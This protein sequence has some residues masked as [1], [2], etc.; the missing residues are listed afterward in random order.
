MLA[1]LADMLS[2]PTDTKVVRP[3]I[4]AVTSPMDQRDLKQD[5]SKEDALRSGLMVLTLRKRGKKL[6][7]HSLAPLRKIRSTAQKPTG[8]SLLKKKKKHRSSGQ[9]RLP[10]EILVTPRLR[11][12]FRFYI[13]GAIQK[14]SII[15]QDIFGSL[16]TVCT[17]AN[18]AVRCI[19]TSFRI[20]S[21]AMYLPNGG[22]GEIMWVVD[23]TDQGPDEGFDCTIPANISVTEPIVTSPP[24]NSIANDWVNDAAVLA[25]ELLLITSS[26]AG[27]VLD[28]DVEY[29][30]PNEFTLTSLTVAAATLGVFYYLSLDDSTGN[31]ITAINRPTTT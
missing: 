10:P 8:F 22:S 14:R 5:S 27:A 6:I 12:T 23:N 13:T 17:V 30:L 28:M 3:A 9:V 11:Q 29:T 16:G 1:S 26:T 20:C 18:S 7:H 15:L 2:A 19:A 4:A 24:A 25:D 21:L 31:N